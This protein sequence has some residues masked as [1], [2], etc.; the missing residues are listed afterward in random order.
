MKN[1]LIYHK[2]RDFNSAFYKE[3]KRLLSD[4][5][6]TEI[7]DI[8]LYDRAINQHQAD[9]VL[10]FT[11]KIDDS[12]KVF[13][14]NFSKIPHLLITSKNNELKAL[15]LLEIGFK[16]YFFT[17][18]LSKL[19]AVIN[20][21]IK[22]NEILSSSLQTVETLTNYIEQAPL[23]TITWDLDFKVVN[24]NKTA[25]EVFGYTA[26]EAIGKTCFELTVPKGLEETATIL[27]K[28]LLNQVGKTDNINE[29]LK[30]NGEII[31]CHWHNTLLKDDA[32]NI[33]GIISSIEDITQKQED[34]RDLIKKKKFLQQ[35]QKL[36]EVFNIEIS[37]DLQKVKL[38]RQFIKLSGLNPLKY[39]TPKYLLE[40]LIHPQDRIKLLRSFYISI[41]KNKKLAIDI[42]VIYSNGTIRWI[43]ILADFFTDENTHKK[44]LLGTFIDV[45]KRNNEL[46]QLKDQNSKL[47]LAI[48]VSKLGFLIFD[49]KTNTVEV[50][51]NTHKIFDLDKSKNV[52]SFKELLTRVHPK[53][54][55]KVE[56]SLKIAIENCSP[57]HINH[58]LLLPNGSIIW[59]NARGE[60]TFDKEHK[61]NKLMG[62]VKDVT[63]QIKRER[64]LLEHSLIL[65]Q[66]SSIVLVTDNHTNITFGTPSVLKLTGY[67]IEEVLGQGWWDNTFFS[68]EA[69]LQSKKFIRSAFNDHTDIE[70]INYERKIRCKDGTAKWFSWQFSKGT[71]NSI[72]SLGTDIT[73]EKENV[74][75]VNK[76]YRAIEKSPTIVVITDVKGNIEFVNPKFE[77]VTGYSFKDV[78]GKNPHILSTGYT[79]KTEYKN[80]W[81]TISSGKN[82]KGEFKNKKKDGCIYWE[83]AIIT[84]VKDNE[85]IITNY[86]AL[87]EDITEKKIQEKKFLYALFEAQENE[88]LKFG[89]ELHDSLSQVLSAM[90][91]YIE[92]V[93][94]PKNTKDRL[95]VEYLEKIRQLAYD[96]L[97]ETRNISQGLMSKQLI[98]SGLVAA[99]LEVCTNY[100]DSKKINFTFKNT[101]YQETNFEIEKKQ[102]IFRIIQEIT[103]NIVKH[104]KATKAS[105]KFS[106]KNDEWF[107]LEINDNG[108][109]IDRDLIKEKSKCFGLKNIQ[110]RVSL[111]NGII[112][113]ES[114]PKIGTK[115]IIKLPLTLK[116]V[117]SSLN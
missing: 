80:L 65:N 14:T 115:Y 44:S 108:I 19:L 29:S 71:E 24:W 33:K 100:N 70:H 85:G 84:P 37:L 39:Y 61:P 75:L 107:V 38:D 22:A 117:N 112:N 46:L 41:K 98:E 57:Y 91:F 52:F 97:H 63:I 94:N 27:F 15:S 7:E 4:F 23:A 66:I 42:R 76:L 92:A 21:E 10:V 50:S 31:I 55:P 40:N 1:L 16:D 62:I 114:N 109:G 3:S 104:S 49:I 12:L 53:D 26:T 79:S 68:K 25:E 74:Q 13:K 87:K 59:V 32:D 106:I 95:K 72:I 113:R 45:T 18:S 96:A 43:N 73:K 101:G 30:K 77:E 36:S 9:C 8:A 93:L 6:I 103:S 89:E 82:W 116:H 78:K 105:I 111:L 48:E 51:G 83:S 81:K 54:R 17:E 11:S 86:I 60:V 34:K 5:N 2:T 58:R 47:D 64:M 56:K 20:R 67:S 102:N 69:C 28:D 90:S 110:Q 35:A 88:K 99:T